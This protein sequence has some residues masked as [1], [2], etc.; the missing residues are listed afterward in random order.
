MLSGLGATAP[1]KRDINNAGADWSNPSA[2]RDPKMNRVYM[3][4]QYSYLDGIGGALGSDA[5]DINNM[6]YTPQ[7]QAGAIGQHT[8]GRHTGMYQDITGH[9]DL[10]YTM[11]NQTLGQPQGGAH[12]VLRQG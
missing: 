7:Y 2:E 10:E 5:I 4:L 6:N 3:N 12:T 8:D 11:Y 9:C 1:Q